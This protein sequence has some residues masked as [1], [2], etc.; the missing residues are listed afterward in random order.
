MNKDKTIIYETLNPDEEPYAEIIKDG[1]RSIKEIKLYV[2]Q[3]TL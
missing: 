3:N 1:I 2:P